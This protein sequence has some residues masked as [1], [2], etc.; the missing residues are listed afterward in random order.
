MPARE[1]ALETWRRFHA[2]SVEDPEAF[3]AEQAAFIDWHRPFARVLESSN[4]PFRSWF[5]GGET[6]LCHNAVD[7]HLA[8]RAAQP[9]LAWIS[10]EVEQQ[11]VY[12][13]A[14]LHDEVSRC[15]AILRSLGVGRGDRVLIYLPMI[16]EAVFA[17]LATVR[18]GA[19]HSV[20]FGGFAAGS[21][22]ARI[23]D[24]RP[25]VLVTAYAGM[26]MGKVIALKPLADEAIRLSA[27]P[28][29]KVLIVDR[30]LEKMSRVAG[31]DVDYARA[32]EEH[33]G[34]AVPVEWLE[35]N[36]PSYILYTSGTTGKPKG[37]QRDTGG[38]AV[39]LAA[40]MRHI[41]CSNPGEAYFSTS[42]IGWVV[43][44]SYIVYGPLLNGS[45]TL[46]YEGLPVRPD[47]GIWW[48]IVQDWRVT[49]MFT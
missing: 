4:L 25:K 12:T 39:A 19:I 35:S 46:M 30:G 23:D 27:Q 26:R 48:R 17:M 38:H 16:P 15:A 3:W 49:S 36:E 45:T 10:T 29:A 47:P 40:S 5:V 42:D 1:A 43:G 9:A 13:Y 14:E 28:P 37:V 2:R 44:H 32:R 31:R 18:L 21:L 8:E 22:A 7:R 11:R 20:V 24:A 34:V 33:A 6:N 41:Y